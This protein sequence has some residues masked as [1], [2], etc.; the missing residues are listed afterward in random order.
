MPEGPGKI[1]PNDI[2]RSSL[3]RVE[4]YHRQAME[5]IQKSGSETLAAIKESSDRADAKIEEL[6][7]VINELAIQNVQLNAAVKATNAGIERLNQTLDTRLTQ[8]TDSINGHLRVA[9]Q[10]ERT[11]QQN[12]TN[13]SELIAAVRQQAATVDRL[14]SKN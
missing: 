4:G 1:T 3:D 9:E 2:L 8:L 11:A 6:R 12:A 7:L 10:Q 5:A 14:L 13:I